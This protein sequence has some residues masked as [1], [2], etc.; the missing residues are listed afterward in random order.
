MT[1]HLKKL[2]EWKPL[3]KNKKA[4]FKEMLYLFIKDGLFNNWYSNIKLYVFEVNVWFVR[5]LGLLT[6]EQQ[7]LNFKHTNKKKYLK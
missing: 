3:E 4:E 1:W 7:I 5:N 6:N 2:R